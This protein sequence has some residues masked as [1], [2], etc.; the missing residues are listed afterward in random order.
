MKLEN[1]AFDKLDI[2]ELNMRHGRKAPDVSDILP[3]VRA[4]GILVPL[5]VRPKSAEPDRFEIVA[6]RRRWFRVKT[7]IEEGGVSEP[8]PCAIMEAGDDAAALE[9]SLIE[10]IARLDP[11]EVSQW[12]TFTRLIQK[13]GR[14]VEQIAQ[15]FGVTDLHVRRVL[16]LGNLV[17]R[18]RELYRA[19]EINGVTVRHLT[20]ATR[21]QQK[22]WLALWSDPEN[23]APTGAQLKAWLFGGASISTKAALFDLATYQGQIVTDLFGEDGYFADAD[24]FW[25]A[26]NEAIAARRDQL[27]E[28]GWAEVEVLEIGEPFASWEFEKTPMTEG[29]KI[30]IT[31]SAHGDVEIHAGFLSRKEARRKRSGGEYTDPDSPPK[32]LRPEVSG[33][34]QTYIDLH[35]H[36]AVRAELARHSGVAL[37]LMLAHAINGSPLWKVKPEPQNSRGEAMRISLVDSAAEAQFAESSQTARTLLDVP[38]D[39]DHLSG[40]N[41]DDY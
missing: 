36:A 14:T 5:L 18:I 8:L 33:P 38:K 3:S 39:Y 41:G 12:E 4:R 13:E 20:L 27:V 10:N 34:M 15:T 1:I 7:L 29:G 32:S 25:I 16:A 6:G 26:Q 19:D 23:H 22:R 35:R 30:F 31:V 17:P 2:S 40:G 21:S 24:R 37:R 28:D 11:D 9:A